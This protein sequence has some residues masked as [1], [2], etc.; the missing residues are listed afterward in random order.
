M[1]EL[2]IEL[3]SNSAINHNDITFENKFF[4]EKVNINGYELQK[5]Y[6][7]YYTGKE[8]EGGGCCYFFSKDD[9]KW[10]VEVISRY[11]GEL[12]EINTP[13]NTIEEALNEWGQK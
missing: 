3:E 5:V 13:Y 11:G 9:H 8:N 7:F 6:D 12:E 1:N 2:N 10:Y 4:N